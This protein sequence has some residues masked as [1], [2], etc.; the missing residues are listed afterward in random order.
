MNQ[1]T[2]LLVQRI[3]PPY[4]VSLFEE[5]MR[6]PLYSPT[7]A[8]GEALKHDALGT[9]TNLSNLNIKILRNSYFT[10]GS[11]PII[12]QRGLLALI[13]SKKYSIIIAEFNP[14]ILS[15]VIACIYAKRL[16][17]RFVWWGHG[18]GRHSRGAIMRF[19]LWL[20]RLAD[21][22]IL[23]D[24]DQADKFV[25]LG[26]PRKKIFVAP[27]SI[28]TQEVSR[29]ARQW[30]GHE[31]NRVLYIG[32]LIH[33]KKVPLLI[34][35]FASAYPY[36]KPGAKLT[37]I[38]DGPERSNLEQLAMKL[39]LADQVEFIGTTYEQAQLAPWFNTT[40]VSVAPGPVGLSAIHSF[41]YGVPMLV[42]QDEPHGPEVS[43]IH[44]GE[45][46]LFFPS[47]R[48]EELAR[49]LIQLSKEQEQLREMASAARRTVQ[50][51]F[52]LSAMAEAFE[53]AVEYVQ[54]I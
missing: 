54:S 53:R 20:V 49:R 8:Y 51:H 35:G 38:G 42:A 13:R 6:S 19:R 15:N 23:Y 7:L 18:M 25:S 14:R 28:D 44:D 46:A 32:R 10:K 45:N 50:G 48:P 34:R 37:I 40:W 21:A 47:D 52:G 41:A 29:F 30:S 27:N 11:E 26:V 16:G 9:I 36:L 3:I 39:G 31:R 33:N 1:P 24:F 17:I 2:V 43:V 5:L 22:I 12:Y 4:R